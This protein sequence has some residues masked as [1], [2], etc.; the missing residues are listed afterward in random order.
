MVRGKQ[1]SW[2]L[3]DLT[4]GEY[5]MRLMKMTYFPWIILKMVIHGCH[6]RLKFMITLF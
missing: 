4:H 6:Y 2:I 5:F 3:M 1:I